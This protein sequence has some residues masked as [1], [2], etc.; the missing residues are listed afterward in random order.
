MQYPL[1]LYFEAHIPQFHNNL[2]LAYLDTSNNST[3]TD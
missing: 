1:H 3:N 2:T